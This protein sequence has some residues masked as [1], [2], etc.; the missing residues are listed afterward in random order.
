IETVKQGNFQL[1]KFIGEK[2]MREAIDINNKRSI[3]KIVEYTLR[4]AQDKEWDFNEFIIM[5]TW[6]PKK[7]ISATIAL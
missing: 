2:I 3:R 4:E 6:K 7:K 1:L 5:G